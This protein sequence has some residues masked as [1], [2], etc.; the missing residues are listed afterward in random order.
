MTSEPKSMLKVFLAHSSP[1]KTLVRD[2]FF[3]L[4]VD[5]FKPWLDEQSLVGGQDWEDSIAKA[6]K[7]ADVV[8]VF[9]SH[10]SV[11]RAGYLH[12]EVALALDIAARQPEASIFVV[13]IRLDD[14]EVPERLTH[15]H[16]LGR[17]GHDFSLGQVYRGLQQ[18]LVLRAEQVGLL[19]DAKF[20]GT[21]Y[22]FLGNAFFTTKGVS[23]FPVEGDY[24]VRGENPDRTKYYGTARIS[25]GN[26]QFKLTANIGRHMLTYVGQFNGSVLEFTGEHS[27]TYSPRGREGVLIGEW[28]AG[29]VEELI[30]ASPFAKLN[31]P[32]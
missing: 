32:C 28:G 10:N 18:S 11:D 22:A 31:L 15:L 25:P 27:V 19:T 7:Q 13:P 21:R 12:K 26:R 9:L 23:R 20:A 6:V 2:I 29:G 8:A 5:G 1:D 14:C 16:W 24:L 17:E 3:L 4:T 30:P